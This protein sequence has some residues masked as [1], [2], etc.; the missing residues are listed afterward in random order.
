METGLAYVTYGEA[1]KGL[2]MMEAGIR[3]G[4]LRF[5]DQA[6]LRLGYAYY[7]AGDKAK[8]KA[9]FA[10]VA[11]KDGARDLARLWRQVP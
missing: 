8:A 11:G 10:K 4:G 5:P 1:V 2:K 6:Q 7:Y 3:K 9:A